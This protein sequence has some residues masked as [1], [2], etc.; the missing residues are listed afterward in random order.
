V[1][2]AFIHNQQQP[3]RPTVTVPVVTLGN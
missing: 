2:I 1:H 3:H